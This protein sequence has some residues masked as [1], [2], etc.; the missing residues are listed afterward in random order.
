MDKK[1]VSVILK[2]YDKGYSVEEIA[3]VVELP[4]EK[5]LEVIQKSKE[6]N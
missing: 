6:S 1:A 5:V 3:D 2:M 4:K